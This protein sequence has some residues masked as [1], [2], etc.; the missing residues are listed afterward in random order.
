MDIS[1]LTRLLFRQPPVEPERSVDRW[2]RDALLEDALAQPARG[3]WD[4][5]RQA[6][7]DRKFR[8]HGMWV[9]DEPPNDTPEPQDRLPC[10]QLF[11]HR[12]W[13][14]SDGNMLEWQFRDTLR[15]A[16]WGWM[17]PLF[18]GWTNW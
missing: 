9:L 18:P 14:Y 15:E 11:R 7:T 3:S 17:I 2:I 1:R 12:L 5:L 4:R 6:I 10:A 13:N 8:K 16:V